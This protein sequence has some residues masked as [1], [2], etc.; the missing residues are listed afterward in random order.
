MKNKTCKIKNDVTDPEWTKSFWNELDIFIL[1]SHIQEALYQLQDL[2]DRMKA[3]KEFVI[4]KDFY[5]EKGI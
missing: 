3:Y 2:F 1:E 5:D 4:I